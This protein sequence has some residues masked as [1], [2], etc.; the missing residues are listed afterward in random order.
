[1]PKFTEK[2]R[3]ISKEKMVKR[4]ERLM[5]KKIARRMDQVIKEERKIRMKNANEEEI[6]RMKKKKEE[7][8]K[9]KGFAIKP[10]D[11][12][13]VNMG[14][15]KTYYYE[16]RTWNYAIDELCLYVDNIIESEK[17]GVAEM[18][19]DDIK[20]IMGDKITVVIPEAFKSSLKL[21]MRKR[22]YYTKEKFDDGIIIF[23]KRN[24]ENSII[25]KASKVELLSG[26]V[27][28]LNDDLRQEYDYKIYSLII[29]IRNELFQKTGNFFS[30]KD[31]V[32]MAIKGGIDYV[33]I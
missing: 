13:D 32:E 20:T 24:N 6:A 9:E 26:I 12:K 29:D 4:E 10:S 8:E 18:R 15:R 11:K 2:T 17:Y 28:D 1:M 25:S 19:I 27:R 23:G 7:K 5:A 21:S 16:K 22:G 14:L 33:E 3:N 31:M 30:I